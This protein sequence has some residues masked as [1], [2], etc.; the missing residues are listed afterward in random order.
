MIGGSRKWKKRVGVNSG[1]E[2]P[3]PAYST[4]RAQP[5]PTATNKLKGKIIIQR[6]A[7]MIPGNAYQDSG[8]LEDKKLAW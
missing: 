3:R 2:H 1:N 4:M 5:T 6:I 7:E 8:I